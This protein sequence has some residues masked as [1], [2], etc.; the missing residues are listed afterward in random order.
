MIAYRA[1]QA[2]QLEELSISDPVAYQK[3]I[4]ADRVASE[5]KNLSNNYLKNNYSDDWYTD[6]SVKTYN[7]QSIRWTQ[8]YK[9]NKTKIIIHHSASDNTT[10]KSQ[11]DAIDY[12]KVT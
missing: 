5:K 11:K 4:D 8:S 1:N 6:D 3:K 10:I 9:Y 7:G 2:K 12:I